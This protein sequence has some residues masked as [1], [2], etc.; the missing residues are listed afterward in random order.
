MHYIRRRE[1]SFSVTCHTRICSLHFIG[2]K[3]SGP[4]LFPWNA[5]KLFQIASPEKRRRQRLK[6]TDQ[7]GVCEQR[8]ES[9]VADLNSL[10]CLA[11]VALSNGY[12]YVNDS[13]TSTCSSSQS[14]GIPDGR[15]VNH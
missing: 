1:K 4:Q 13:D 15:A 9:C 11:D 6:Q 5:E 8:L 2:D 10:S 14:C 12:L 7:A 3:R